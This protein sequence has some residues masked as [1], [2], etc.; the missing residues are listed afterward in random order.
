[1]MSLVIEITC[2]RTQASEWRCALN[3]PGDSRCS[4]SSRQPKAD[5]MRPRDAANISILELT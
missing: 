2:A 4:T 3:G 1:M 5:E